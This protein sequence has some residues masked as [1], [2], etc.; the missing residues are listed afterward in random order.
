MHSEP[1]SHSIDGTCLPRSIRW[2]L[3]LGVLEMPHVENT[4]FSARC[5]DRLHSTNAQRIRLARERYDRLVEKYDKDSFRN[6]FGETDAEG[7]KGKND[8]TS[9]DPLSMLVKQDEA[10]E[11][12]EA[13]DREVRKVSGLHDIVLS[14][15]MVIVVNKD[16]ARL[17]D[18][19]ASCFRSRANWKYHMQ[20]LGEE[21]DFEKARNERNEC[22][23]QMLHVYGKEHVKPGYQQ[24]MD[25]I[26]SYAMLVVEMDL[27]DAET[28]ESTDGSGLISAEH[29]LHDSFTL[30]EAIL[31]HILG[32]FGVCEHPKEGS[33][34]KMGASILQKIQYVARNKQLYTHLQSTKWCLSLYTARW[35]RLLF[36]REV[37]G[38]R[39]TLALWDVFFDCISTAT[40]ITSMKPSKYTRPGLTPE[41][42]LGEFDLMV[43]LEMTA[44]SLIWMR[45]D[46]LLRQQADD[47]LQVLTAMVPLKEVGPLISTLL[48]SLRR[49]QISPNMAPLLH[50]DNK[51]VKSNYQSAQAVFANPRKA[52]T[53]MLSVQS[54]INTSQRIQRRRPS[55][56][57]IPALSSDTE[58]ANLRAPHQSASPNAPKRTLDHILRLS[59]SLMPSLSL[60]TTP[61]GEANASVDK[62]D[63]VPPTSKPPLLKLEEGRFNFSRSESASCLTYDS[64][65]HRVIARPAGIATDVERPT[66]QS[67]TGQVQHIAA[68]MDSVTS[69]CYAFLRQSSVV[70]DTRT[71]DSHFEMNVT[72]PLEGGI[73]T[74]DA[75][76]EQ[77]NAAFERNDAHTSAQNN[78]KIGVHATAPTLDQEPRCG[79]CDRIDDG[80]VE[81]VG[82]IN[83]SRA[84]STSQEIQIS[85]SEASYMT[86][87]NDSGCGSGGT[88]SHHFTLHLV[89]PPI[90][91]HEVS[92]NHRKTMDFLLSS[93]SD[94]SEGSLFDL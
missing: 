37:D 87:L 90:P 64:V 93:V 9:L 40:A 47:G 65:P 1:S 63:F 83:V 79:G 58:S 35:V 89:S 69:I 74:L 60:P 36:A 39:S 73:T 3:Q 2:R 75:N 14:N 91:V 52:F 72:A 31:S 81:S 82:S 68:S 34:E 77:E 25:E 50:P 12:Q 8:D 59:T 53:R 80:L 32:A 27:F 30:A 5:L 76:D 48:S 13:K 6:I 41:L 51:E 56:Q 28:T 44:A 85:T 22:L 4:N 49:L 94:S 43:V 55:L 16:L 18:Y 7:D 84:F 88:S 42:R 21:T 78:P 38:W 71:D 33:V 61:L 19:H 62:G 86:T 92:D 11:E 66:R 23:M 10:R 70:F 26:F 17:P 15:E 24:G 57:H 46:I 45:R 29:L 54:E 20:N 67:S